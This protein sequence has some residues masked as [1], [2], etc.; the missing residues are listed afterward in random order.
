[1]DQWRKGDLLRVGAIAV[2]VFTAFALTVRSS[3]QPQAAADQSGTT[4]G[5]DWSLRLEPDATVRILHRGAEII[6]STNVFWGPKGWAWAGP[7]FKIQESS[8]GQ[9]LLV[10]TIAGLKLKVNGRISS[11]T[12]N[13]LV[14]DLDFQ[15]AESLSDVVGGGWNWDLKLDSPSFRQRL[16]DPVL[17]ENNRGWS[18]QTA[19]GQF[20]SV[21]FEPASAR[22][23]FETGRK[24]QIR[25]FLV[26]KSLEAGSSQIRVTIQL[27][28]G[29]SRVPSTNELYGPTD[30]QK[31][32]RGAL[33]WNS[34]P[35][36]LS[37]LNR[38]DK[39]AGRRGFVRAKGDQFVHG[40]GTPA[41][42]WGGN[43]AAYVLFSTPRQNVARQAHR[44]A[45]LGYNLMRIHHHDSGWVKPNIFDRRYQDTRHLSSESLENLD[46]WIKC[47]K[48]EGIYVWLDMHVGRAFNTADGITQGSAEIERAKGII[49]GFDYY[50]SQ[51]QDL[52][53]EFHHK[54]LNH[55]NRYTKLRYKEDPAVMGVLITNEDDLT[56][57]GGNLMLPDKNTPAH[58]ALWT[59]GYKA[60][61]SQ[62]HL[63]ANRVFQTWVAGPSKLY[64]NE[65]EHNFNQ[66]MIGD[67]RS[68]GLKA[69]IATTNFWGNNPLFSLP[70]LTDG[71]MI[72]VHSYGL[73]EAMDANAHYEGNYISWIAQA[74][75]YGKPL[76]ITEWN[77]EYPKVD[78]FTSPL[79]V[80]SI[81]SLQGWDAP[82]I[83]NYSQVPL[84]PPGRPDVWSTFFDPS[85]TGVMPAAAL[86]FRQG[87]VA[88]AKTT[89]CL[90]INPDQLFNRDLMP[91]KSAT[92][93]T[94]AEQ[95]KLTI[96]LPQVKELPWLKPIKPSDDVTLIDDLD[97][98][99]IPEGQNYVRSDT[100]E[101]TRDWVRG[102]Q[103]IDTPKTQSV[104][105][106][107]GGKTLKTQ[108]VN[109]Q[110]STRK[111]VLVLSSI[112]N[113]PLSTSGFIMIT[114]MARVLPGPGSGVP[115]LSEPVLA[116]ISMRSQKVGLQLIALNADGLEISR[117][118]PK[119]VG[120]MLN[121]E[122]P[123][124]GGTH[125][126]ALKSSEPTNRNNDS[127]K[128]VEASDPSN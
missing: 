72:D 123:T 125:W 108:D 127:T 63:P 67:L 30:T 102:I 22:T 103:V 50:N 75:V 84:I 116:K 117:S 122:L 81:S 10:G 105:G 99:F 86:L 68:L 110:T 19:P 88:P 51:A 121:F 55:E 74:Q 115:L 91:N 26:A 101:L 77:V 1:M 78:R 58:N 28:E 14:M 42:F 13:K 111:A 33:N 9:A 34:S 43:L 87:H 83:Y 92:I 112:D 85:L 49:K 82:M 93:R 96:G 126:Y 65:V 95:S 107:I 71:D 57:H 109:F 16:A 59:Q 62:Y 97:H 52:M 25:T 21:S 64:L 66:K 46:W 106:W 17:L 48:D 36:D 6:R 24:N 53:M 56:H 37:F 128:N 7:S 113:R 73:S 20:L 61:A 5:S 8:N 27:P 80:A 31:W 38:N 98:D 35:V 2:A 118:T 45:Q 54:Y 69:P 44:M 104:S 12:S 90:M 114:A 79:Y 76:T 11:P 47:L 119:R 124:G 60:F 41:R 15:A 18:L 39:P 3:E 120:G 40:D 94:L 29:G 70:A 4:L 100:D 89:Y 32:F 23:Y